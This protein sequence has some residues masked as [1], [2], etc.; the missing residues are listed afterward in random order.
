MFRE[1]VDVSS[2]AQHCRLV[3]DAPT[4]IE[5][6]AAQSRRSG[7]NAGIRRALRTG[8]QRSHGSA[9]PSR[10]DS[11]AQTAGPGVDAAVPRGCRCG[12]DGRD[13][14]NLGGECSGADSSDQGDS[15]PPLSCGRPEMTTQIPQNDP[16]LIWQNQRR[17]H[18]SMTVEEVRLRAYTLQ[19][20]IHRNLIVTIAVGFA[21]LVFSAMMIMRLPYTPPRVIVVVLMAL[22]V[23]TINKAYRAFWA[24]DTLPHDAT[25]SACLDFYR[26]ELT[27]QYR[28]VALT[29]RRLLPEIGLLAVVVRISFMASFRFDTARILLPVFLAITLA[30]RYWRARKLKR[31][32]ETLS[33]FEKEDN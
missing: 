7:H 11:S 6:A 33:T 5:F 2:R 22:I 30:G 16:R 31:E 3:C 4:P 17:E 14:G 28:A 10:A 21:L 15:R 26:R 19:T 32:L 12:D 13:H 1:N 8:L 27:A 18:S 24:P 20:R 29:W 25:P 9:A 23:I